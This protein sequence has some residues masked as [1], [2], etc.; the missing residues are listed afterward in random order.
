MFAF[1][2]DIDEETN[3]FLKNKYE[4]LKPSI[5]PYTNEDQ[6]AAND[7]FYNTFINRLN[8]K[9]KKQPSHYI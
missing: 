3:E 1:V 7:D 9:T 5:T 4:E 6:Q 8:E 2:L